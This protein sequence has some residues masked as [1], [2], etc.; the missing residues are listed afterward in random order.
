MA[1]D[2]LATLVRW[3]VVTL[4][5]GHGLIHLLGAA[6]GLGWA[7]VSQ[8]RHP[9]GP[10][11]GLVWL[12][13]AVLVLGSAALVAAGGVSWWWTVA[14][15]AAGVSELAVI[16][17]W[18][19]AKYGT[20]ANLALVLVA[21]YGF[22]SLGPTSFHAQYDDRVRDALAD[23][24]TGSPALLTERDLAGL[25]DP[26]A[27]YVRRSGAIGKPRVTSFS[28]A[29]H[30]RIRSAPDQAWMPF[31]GH[32]VNTFGP[33][34]RR[35]FLMD[36]TRSGLPVTVL[37]SFR[38]TTATMRARVLS[39][40]TVVDASGAEMDRGETVTVFNDLVV[41]APGAIVDAPVVWT[42][43]DEHHV[44]GEFTDGDQTVTAVLE[45]DDDHDLVDFVSRDR[46]RASANGRTF[47]HQPWSTPL[48]AH[49]DSHGRRVL[50]SG[51]GRWHAPQPEGLFTYVELHVDGITYNV[52]DL[53]GSSGQATPALLSP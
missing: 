3:V 52:H 1:P 25:P 27:A 30:G 41:L 42:P 45:F 37:H 34:P 19:D 21:G 16:S 26:L 33:R 4:L 50:T 23:A 14:L 9:I 7:E 32:Q 13:A 49:R 6:K 2:S 47:E 28:A 5:M 38:D 17:S 18:S 48:A 39:A 15:L 20:A 46:L 12:L 44:R 40:I 36:A 22:A 43:V 29:F 24:P 53:D 35:V 11:G 8:L 31:T 51:E 10:V